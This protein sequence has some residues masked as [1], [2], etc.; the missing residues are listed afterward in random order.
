MTHFKQI[1]ASCFILST[2]V[3]GAGIAADGIAVDVVK[4][5]GNVIHNACKLTAPPAGS[6]VVDAHGLQLL[7]FPARLGRRY[8][9]CQKTWFGEGDLFLSLVYRDGQLREAN[10]FEPEKE[11]ITCGYQR[12]ML[13]SGPKEVCERIARDNKIPMR[14]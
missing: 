8:T 14:P 13:K 9:G 7:T 2:V 3:A 11:K 1:A 5:H 10:F 4:K 6:S 12:G